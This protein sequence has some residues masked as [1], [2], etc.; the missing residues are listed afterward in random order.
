MYGEIKVS[1]KK[2]GDLV[3]EQ[4]GQLTQVQCKTNKI[5]T[6]DLEHAARLR[7]FGT[8]MRLMAM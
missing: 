3:N 7:V 2:V 4:L 1:M 8:E 6:Q 5:V